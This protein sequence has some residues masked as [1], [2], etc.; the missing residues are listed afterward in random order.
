MSTHQSVDAVVVGAGFAGLYQIYRFRECGLSV[1]GFEAA[2]G[3]GG[4]WWWNRYPGARCDVESMDYSYGFSA[5]LDQDWTWSEKYATQPEILRY[6]EHVAERLDL[7]R[8]ITFGTRVESAIYDSDR[9]RWTISASNGETVEARW[10]VM[11]T[12]CLSVSKAPEIPGADRFTG[13]IY[14]TGDWPHEGM[15]FAGK[16]IAVIGTGSSGIQSIPILAEQAAHT[17]VFQRTPTFSMPAGNRPL[18]DVEINAR[19]AEY[20]DYR[21]RQKE[22]SFGVPV[23]P[24]TQSALE[25]CE[26]DRLSTY[27][28]AWDSGRLTG[29]LGAYTDLLVDK[30]AN[31]TAAEFVRSKIRDIVDEPEVA[32]LLS[33]HNYPFGSKRPCLDSGYYQTFNK[34]NVD[35]IDLR[36]TPLIEITETGIRTSRQ[37]YAFDAIVFATGFDAMTG[38]L[39]R[40]NI[41]GEGGMSLADK[42]SEGPRSYLGLA[43]AGFPNL[44]TVTGPSSPSVLSNMVVSIEQHVDWITEC[45]QWIR[46]KGADAI[47]ATESAESDWIQHV[48]MVGNSTLYPVADSWY[49]GANVPGKPRILMAYVGGV[50]EYRKICDDVARRDYTGFTTKAARV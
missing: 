19:K 10:V 13:P 4:T 28:A 42:W 2:S 24:P 46:E 44:F 11:A 29:L 35:I 14:H 9:C 1:R 3:V 8:H 7:E 39:A 33:S 16:R 43:V 31:D 37:E 6:L 49:V 48:E 40:I 18:T 50:G 25:V 22:S 45:V 34:D 21:R 15:D 12:G 27:Q 17:T 36:S 41:R 20:P 32:A 23:A 5:D 47:D 30:A 26:A 38:A